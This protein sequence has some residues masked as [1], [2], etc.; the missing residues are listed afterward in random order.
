[1]KEYQQLQSI[2]LEIYLK[3]WQQ[4][5]IGNRQNSNIPKI[6]FVR[7]L[8]HRPQIKKDFTL[9]N[10]LQIPTVKERATWQSFVAGIFRFPRKSSIHPC[11]D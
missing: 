2:V 3:K 9:G 6:Y 10:L 7:L 8:K 1:M 4:F 11:A 5:K